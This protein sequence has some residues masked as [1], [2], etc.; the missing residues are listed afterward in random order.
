MAY[1]GIIRRL[2]ISQPKVVSWMAPAG[3]MSLTNYIFQSISTSMVFGPWGFGLFQ[4]LPV[5]TVFLLAIAIWLTLVFLSTLWLK[6]FNQGPLE[7]LMSKVT[8][9]KS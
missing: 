2:L 7:K 4:E 3:K 5:W 6:R 8:S 1:V 9:K